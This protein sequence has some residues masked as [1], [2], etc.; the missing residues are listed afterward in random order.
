MGDPTLWQSIK[1]W[2][3]WRMIWIVCA[4]KGHV[5]RHAEIFTRENQEYPQDGC[6]CERCSET[7]AF[8]QGDA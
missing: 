5:M 6:I 7:W 4:L 2:F 3:Y 1:M 8:I